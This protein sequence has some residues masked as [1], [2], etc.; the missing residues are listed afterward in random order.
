MF[1]NPFGNQN[2]LLGDYHQSPTYKNLSIDASDYHHS[3]P[4]TE[5][6]LLPTI[7]IMNNSIS[8]AKNENFQR[9]VEI[10]NH[11][12]KGFLYYIILIWVILVCYSSK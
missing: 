8:S 3:N 5:S 10:E 11:I 7:H 12:T 4:N 6:S 1:Q 2:N 9:L